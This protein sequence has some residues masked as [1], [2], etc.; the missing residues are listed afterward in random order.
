MLDTSPGFQ[1]FGFAGGLYDPDTGLVRFGAR[2]YN[3][4]VGRWTSKDP[5]LFGGGDPNLYG[6]VLN[7]PVHLRDENGEAP[8]VFCTGAQTGIDCMMKCAEAG[9]S[10]AAARPHPYKGGGGLGKLYAC[11]SLVIG[12]MCSYAFDNGDSCHFAPWPMPA[13]CSYTGG[14]NNCEP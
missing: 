14:E 5:I 7:D 1:P 2:D 9:I 11:N 8:K 13:L 6:Y 3:A 12:S 10:C 4:E